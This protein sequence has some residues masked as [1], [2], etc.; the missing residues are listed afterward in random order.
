MTPYQQ[1]YSKNQKS[2]K[3]SKREQKLPLNSFMFAKLVTAIYQ[4]KSHY[5]IKTLFRVLVIETESNVLKSY[6]F[7][8]KNYS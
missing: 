8:L 1:L 4:L 3:N 5:L 6:V 7:M 2:N